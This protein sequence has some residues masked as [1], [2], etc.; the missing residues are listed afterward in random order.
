MEL[1]SQAQP[2]E[3]SLPIPGEESFLPL[4]EVADKLL[5]WSL[6]V[7]AEPESLSPRVGAALIYWGRQP[8]LPPL[9]QTGGGGIEAQAGP[10]GPNP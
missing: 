8:S 1:F 7:L 6:Q 5:K 3:A 2:S 9:P 10:S 4:D